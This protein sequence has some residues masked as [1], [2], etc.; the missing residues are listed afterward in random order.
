MPD[1]E[2]Q[3]DGSETNADDIARAANLEAAQESVGE[4]EERILKE[5]LPK[6]HEMFRK[7]IDDESD[8]FGA[9][10]TRMADSVE[11]R[12]DEPMDAEDSAALQEFLQQEEGLRTRASAEMNA[13]VEG[14]GGPTPETL[15]KGAELRARRL[16]LDQEW[17]LL[18]ETVA[19]EGA[20]ESEMMKFALDSG[21]DV[22]PMSDAAKRLNEVYAEIQNIN[23][24]LAGTPKAQEAYPEAKAAPIYPEAFPEG[25]EENP[26]PLTE[27]MK[28]KPRVRTG[29]KPPPPPGAEGRAEWLRAKADAET[30]P[31]KK[32]EWT[33]KY[34]DEMHDAD[35]KGESIV[36]DILDKITEKRSDMS[37][38]R[39]DIIKEK[40]RLATFARGA[41]AKAR[42]IRKA[43]AGEL[44]PLLVKYG[45]L[46]TKQV[47]TLNETQLKE[48]GEAVAAFFDESAEMA[49]ALKETESEQPASK[50]EAP[51]DEDAPDFI[52]YTQI[53]EVEAEVARKE[54]QK[55]KDAEAQAKVDRI[56]SGEDTI[57][58][59]EVDAE[60]SEATKAEA[61]VVPEPV[62]TA[63]EEAE[64]PEPAEEPAPEIPKP[65]APKKKR[66]IPDNPLDLLLTP[67]DG[68]TRESAAQK[69]AEEAPAEADIKKA[70]ADEIQAALA[71]ESE[72]EVAVK[73]S[74]EVESGEAE[75]EAIATH[76]ERNDGN[77][78][79]FGELVG[80]LDS[81]LSKL[82]GKG[83]DLQTLNKPNQLLKALNGAKIISRDQSTGILNDV[84][85]KNTL[86]TAFK[87]AMK[88][89]NKRK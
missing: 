20:D 9:E 72:S 58:W 53:E 16:Q 30:D 45:F 31:V 15:K 46:K 28:K 86:M 47:D 83:I 84:V 81:H 82:E 12:Y 74:V 79:A 35:L 39:L 7:Y 34:L 18:A 65:E 89:R 4:A 56:F 42:N 60:G 54:A 69:P 23:K 11:K 3:T 43:S 52:D 44:G 80:D 2:T 62:E 68:G 76:S 66:A 17:E 77:A 51:K 26:I 29:E 36:G 63:V 22:P 13:V 85:R 1:T 78:E 8:A 50:K 70:M 37:E 64:A 6:I 5:G 55:M 67:R 61:P 14:T 57:D 88:S 25:S 73:K 10:A 71:E 21:E 38:K 49:R 32:Q 59:T 87:K 75:P 24:E 41:D 48:A 19:S 33:M 27:D 40:G